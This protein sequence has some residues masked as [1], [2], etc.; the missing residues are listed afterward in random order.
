MARLLIAAAVALAALTGCGGDDVGEDDPAE[1]VR[2]AAAG[3]VDALRGERWEEAC[4]RMTTAARAAVGDRPAACAEAPR[5][6][7]ALPRD[8]L[9][10]VARQ[11]AGAH[12]R[13]S[14]ARARLGPVGDLPVPLRF[15]REDGRWLL[16]P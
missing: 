3:F 15:R 13:I 14:G 1:A 4:E 7:A 5:A 9:D 12:V 6:G 11:L 10:T 8:D 2:G 16:A